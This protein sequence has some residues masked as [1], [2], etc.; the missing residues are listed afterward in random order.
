MLSLLIQDENQ[1]EKIIELKSLELLYKVTK[2]HANWR[3][4]S[5]YFLIFLDKITNFPNY[6]HHLK[7]NDS[8]LEALIIILSSKNFELNQVPINEISE[9][10][11]EIQSELQEITNKEERINQSQEKEI[12]SH[13]LKI[14]SRILELKNC[15]DF[16]KKLNEKIFEL[17]QNTKFDIGLEYILAFYSHICVLP[18]L[19]EYI[20]MNKIPILIVELSQ[21][22]L[23]KKDFL[24][25]A[26]YLYLIIDFFLNLSNI[27]IHNDNNIKHELKENYKKLSIEKY[28]LN[29]LTE[30]IQKNE[31]PLQILYSLIALSKVLNKAI[32]SHQK[33]NDG[34]KKHYFDD[35]EE[36]EQ[37]KLMDNIIDSVMNNMKKYP[38][39]EALQIAGSFFLNK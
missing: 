20:L 28:L 11:P 3:I 1:I 7:K 27:A 31:E 12:K 8:C 30:I 33:K 15:D 9:K 19:I 37:K 35:F 2:L 24:G 6:L 4:F 17:K 21:E 13:S 32:A 18:N 25:K 5:F 39:H 16:Q 34:S 23:K 38:D 36:S 26:N 22:L 14:L 29:F 10:E